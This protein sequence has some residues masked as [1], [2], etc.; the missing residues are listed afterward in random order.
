MAKITITIE[1][2]D[3][4]EKQLADVAARVTESVNTMQERVPRSADGYCHCA[5]PETVAGDFTQTCGRC[6][7]NWY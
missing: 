5:Q 6:G 4:S 1:S 3:L 2:D 7:G